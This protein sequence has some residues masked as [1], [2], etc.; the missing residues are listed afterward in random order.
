MEQTL[1]LYKIFNTV[2]KTENISHAAKELYISQPAISKSISHLEEALNTTLFLRTS[3]GVKLTPE[4]KVLYEY[5]KSAFDMIRQG[6]EQL[7][8]MNDLGI[9]ELHIGVT[10]TL[11]KFLLIPI[12][13]EFLLQYPHIKFQINCQSPSE[14][15]A[16]LESG[17]LD[18][19]LIIMPSSHSSLQFYPYTTITDIFVCTEQYLENLKMCSL[20]S[21][22]ETELLKSANFMLLDKSNV[23]RQHLDRYLTDF[24]I[25]E[26]AV[27]EVT[28]MDLLIELA[29]IGV[30]ISGVIKEFVSK[31]LQ[32]KELIELSIPFTIPTRTVAFAYHKSS[33]HSP[34]VQ[35]FLK[36][37]DSYPKNFSSSSFE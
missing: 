5:T 6:E 12:L 10:T 4:G 25:E 29:K 2:A 19:G 9:S 27:L 14:T 18:L 20:P 33:S 7:N 22:S 26:N 23:T 8:K 15:I 35:N 17:Q 24:C 34:T 37:I 16:L 1:S 21:L 13:K 28:D 3:R 30:G 36:F 11:C 31:E 32:A